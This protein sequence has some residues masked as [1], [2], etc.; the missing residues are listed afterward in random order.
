MLKH[1]CACQLMEYLERD[2][3]CMNVF[4]E[5]RGTEETLTMSRIWDLK[6]TSCYVVSQLPFIPAWITS[7]QPTNSP[8][9][10]VLEIGVFRMNVA[11]KRINFRLIGVCLTDLD[12]DWRWH[13]SIT[14]G[15]RP[16]S[17][18]SEHKKDAFPS[19]SASAVHL[20]N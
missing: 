8:G 4:S 1:K 7:N 2:Q 14:A 5:S 18:D 11:V 10:L 16:P 19:W 9:Q 12:S 15:P 17:V 3:S 6:A 20:P 13:L